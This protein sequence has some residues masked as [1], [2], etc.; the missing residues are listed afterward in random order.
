M[1]TTVRFGS[2][3]RP[4]FALSRDKIDMACRIVSQKDFRLVSHALWPLP[5]PLS[6]SRNA[7][8]N[9]ALMSVIE[10]RGLKKSYRVYQ[11]KEGLGAAM[12]GLFRREYREV[13]AV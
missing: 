3:Y 2:A 7:A 11:K 12:R 8:Y 5:M 13:E 1:R 4:N 6:A 9:H 10:I